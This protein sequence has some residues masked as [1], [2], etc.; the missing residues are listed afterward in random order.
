VPPRKTKPRPT[1]NEV[2][3]RAGVAKTTVSHA[4]SGKRPVAPATRERIFKAMHD[5]QYS[6]S[7]IARRLAGSPS[8]TIALVLPL[9]SP[10]I[11][12]VEVRYIASIGAVVNQHGYTFLTLTA[13][14]VDI[15]D[16][17][18]IVYSGL[19]DG[20]LLMRIQ[21]KDERVKLLRETDIPF[22]LIGRTRDNKGLTY[23]DLNG[24]AAIGLAVDYLVELGHHAIG[25]ICPE[26]LNFAFAY[27]IVTGFEKSCEKH[28]LSLV[29]SPAAWSA[30]AGYRATLVLLDQHPEITAI[31]VWSEV[32]TVGA[33]SA[34]RD[35]GRKIPEDISVI[36][37]DRSEHLHLASADL[38][39]IDTRPEG[40][41]GQAAQMLIDLLENKSLEHEQ[42]LMPP[43]LISGKSTARCAN[44][45]AASPNPV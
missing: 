31:I 29:M 41:G 30:D 27:R 8:H 7:P 1:I 33:V 34:L 43:L 25:F 19:V 45:H 20:V 39:V 6:P 12:D 9:A 32:V 14:Q 42:I 26:D 16:L 3:R 11:A 36:S 10:T 44:G 24:E 35:I 13:P 28:Q 38:T 21:Q 18:Q 5:L 17:R 40:V 2:A 37:F 4:I 15:D 22:V 23:V